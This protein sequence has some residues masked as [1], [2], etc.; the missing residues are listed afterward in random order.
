MNRPTGRFKIP[1][2]RFRPQGYYALRRLPNNI[3]PLNAST[4]NA[5][6]SGTAATVTKLS[7]KFAS[8]DTKKSP[9]END[10]TKYSNSDPSLNVPES[11]KFRFSICNGV[12]KSLN[13]TSAPLIKNSVAKKSMLLPS[14]A[15][16]WFSKIPP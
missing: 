7:C 2:S 12:S 6:G 15:L 16:N 8:E 1:R 13:S 9:A 3:M 11:V 4:N 10:A 14:M 5:L